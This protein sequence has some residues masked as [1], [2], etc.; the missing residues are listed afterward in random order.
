LK[1]TKKGFR[2]GS[3]IVQTTPAMINYICKI[4]A[5]KKVYSVLL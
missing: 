5:K 2:V 4:G 3:A 1:V